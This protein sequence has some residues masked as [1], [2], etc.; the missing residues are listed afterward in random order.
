MPPGSTGRS[1]SRPGGRGGV[2]APRDV[3]LG[4]EDDWA[5]E[6]SARCA[7]K[8]R[9]SDAMHRSRSSGAIYPQEPR[10][11]APPTTAFGLGGGR[12]RQ[13][14]ALQCR[15]IHPD[16]SDASRAPSGRN[17]ASSTPF[18]IRGSAGTMH[19]ATGRARNFI[20]RAGHLTRVAKNQAARFVLRLGGR[21][22]FRSVKQFTR[23]ARGG[24][25]GPI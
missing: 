19:A 8:C 18:W 7:R 14:I 10:L 15:P 24:A 9:R 20:S 17:H 11:A 3:S 12:A 23:T 4:M 5:S 13:P 16:S 25:R 22:S 6:A 21:S 1:R 2:P